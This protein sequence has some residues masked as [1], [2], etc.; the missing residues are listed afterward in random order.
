MTSK[1]QLIMT[2]AEARRFVKAYDSAR[3]ELL[4]LNPSESQHLARAFTAL[5]V[6]GKLRAEIG[7]ALNAPAGGWRE[8][9]VKKAVKQSRRGVFGNY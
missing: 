1:V 4:N 7:L 8:G 2:G 5:R 9:E 3:D 6:I